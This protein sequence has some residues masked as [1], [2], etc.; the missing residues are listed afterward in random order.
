MAFPIL[1]RVCRHWRSRL[2][3]LTFLILIHCTILCFHCLDLL[4]VKNDVLLHLS[5][6]NLVIEV[7]D[8]FGLQRLLINNTLSVYLRHIL[9]ILV[10]MG[11][12]VDD[13]IER[14]MSHVAYLGYR[15]NC[16]H[17]ELV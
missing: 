12:L 8:I 4:F 17:Y 16:A 15:V 13:I 9:L 1:H 14:Q 2:L 11:I 6:V 10:Q 3:L 7:D 5:K